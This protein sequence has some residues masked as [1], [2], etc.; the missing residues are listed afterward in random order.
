MGGCKVRTPRRP[1]ALAI[2]LLAATVFSAACAGEQPKHLGLAGNGAPAQTTTGT[3]PPV[4]TA[5]AASS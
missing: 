4:A 2:S 5:G 3:A 1:R